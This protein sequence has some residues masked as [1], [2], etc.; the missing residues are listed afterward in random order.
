M[1]ESYI[2][3]EVLT[4]YNAFIKVSIS[5][6]VVELSPLHLL[7]PVWFPNYIT[8]DEDNA[9]V[10]NTRSRAVTRSITNKAMLLCLKMSTHQISVK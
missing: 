10:R 7:L 5:Q 9:P 3:L 1:L 6:L 2:N 8:Q 4:D